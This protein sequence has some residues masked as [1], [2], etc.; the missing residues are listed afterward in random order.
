MQWA[1]PFNAPVDTTRFAD[2]LNVVKNPLDLGTIK[3]RLEGATYYRDP[4]DV[5]SDINLVFN[6]AKVYNPPGSDVFLMAQTLQV[7]SVSCAEQG[8]ARA[9]GRGEVKGGE[10]ADT[11]Q[12]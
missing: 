1:F 4:K 6:N 3:S 2:Y 10:L 8:H 5:W 12:C 9:V 7:G 11:W